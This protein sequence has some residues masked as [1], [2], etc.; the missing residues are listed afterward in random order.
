[1]VASAIVNARLNSDLA[2]PYRP[3]IGDRPIVISFAT[4]TELRFGAL[5]AGWGELRTRAL[6]RDL[7]AFSVV[8]P[9]D[10]LM[11]ECAALRATCERIG[12]PLGQK[13]HEADRW[14]A[15][16]ARSRDLDLVS[17]DQVFTDSPGLSLLTTRSR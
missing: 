13:V 6:D 7:G 4:V 11:R 1:M 5:K 17:D 12:H 14:I 2:A 16:T 10:E 9:D 15:A 8:Q 3:L